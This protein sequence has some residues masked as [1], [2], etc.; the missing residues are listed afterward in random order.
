MRRDVVLGADGVERSREVG[1]LWDVLAEVV[2][3]SEEA[4]ELLGGGGRG[5]VLQIRQSR[6]IDGPT[7]W[8][9]A[10]S[11]ELDLQ[12]CEMALA[13]VEDQLGLVQSTDDFSQVRRV[14]ASR[15]GENHDIV[16][17]S[18]PF[19]RMDMTLW[20]C[21]GRVLRPKGAPRN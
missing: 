3:K 14:F 21:D 9:D 11:Q 19:S 8:V 18:R 10:E 7:V 12:P 4:L 17:E 2:D 13:D 15:L 20:N 1:D 5:P 6:W 16:D